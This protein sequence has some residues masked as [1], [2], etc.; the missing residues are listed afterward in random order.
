MQNKLI[1]VLVYFIIK[2]M[3]HQSNLSICIPRILNTNKT[4][5][6]NTFDKYQWGVIDN[7][8]IRT[9]NNVCTAFIHYRYWNKTNKAM[10]IKK[11]LMNNEVL[12][13]IY[14]KP[15]FWKCSASRI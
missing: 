11:R 9:K 13:I 3:K 2:K 6:K 4:F 10:Q 7:I 12:N 8:D 14:E 1:D 15:W 5:I